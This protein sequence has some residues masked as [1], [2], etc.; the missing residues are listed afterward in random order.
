MTS[1][2]IY[3]IS[4]FKTKFSFMQRIVYVGNAGN[5][6]E[7]SVQH[8]RPLRY[9]CGEEYRL[10]QILLKKG[11]LNYLRWVEWQQRHVFCFFTP[12]PFISA[13]TIR[14]AFDTS[15]SAQYSTEPA[16]FFAFRPFFFFFFFFGFFLLL[17]PLF[18]RSVGARLTEQPS[19][20][21]QTFPPRSKSRIEAWLIFRARCSRVITLFLL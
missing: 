5:I 15:I 7:I 19:D 11:T 8:T 10:P 20:T 9:S 16:P 18:S 17:L 14:S 13:C 12:A 4:S 2:L 21:P 1:W 6:L 3:P